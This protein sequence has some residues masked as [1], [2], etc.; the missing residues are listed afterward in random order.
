[1]F[2]WMDGC[3]FTGTLVTVRTQNIN[4]YIKKFGLVFGLCFP[5]RE[6]II[7][8]LGAQWIIQI[9]RRPLKVTPNTKHTQ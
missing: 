8:L 4:Y 2:K 3:N 6:G 7:V 9:A 1:M 5:G